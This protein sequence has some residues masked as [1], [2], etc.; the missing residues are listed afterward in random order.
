MPKNSG[1]KKPISGIAANL[2]IENKVC[3]PHQWFWQQIVDQSG[4]KKGE[5]MVCKICGPIASQSGK[6]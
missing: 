5:R 3:P 2:I 4:E 6:D 1:I